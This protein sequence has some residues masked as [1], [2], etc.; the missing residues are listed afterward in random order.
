MKDSLPLKRFQALIQ[1][2]LLETKFENKKKIVKVWFIPG[3]KLDTYTLEIS[4][5][6]R[7]RTQLR[8]EKGQNIQ[9]A[10]TFAYSGILKAFLWAFQDITL[11]QAKQKAVQFNVFLR[12]KFFLCGT[13]GVE[14]DAIT[15]LKQIAEQFLDSFLSEKDPAQ[16]LNELTHYVTASIYIHN[17]YPEAAVAQKSTPGR[18]REAFKGLLNLEQELQQTTRHDSSHTRAI[19]QKLSSLIDS[20]AMRKILDDEKTALDRL[21]SKPGLQTSPIGTFSVGFQILNLITL[22]HSLPTLQKNLFGSDPS[23]SNLTHHKHVPHYSQI[24]FQS[25]APHHQTV[26]RSSLAWIA[27]LCKVQLPSYPSFDQDFRILQ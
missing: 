6:G 23:L 9:G 15:Q 12:L 3:S 4:N 7:P 14:F 10:H 17:L 13:A 5:K 20:N 26:I 2:L 16:A 25:A 11:A 27:D 22:L 24:I 18:E 8:N 21:S 19:L 1:S